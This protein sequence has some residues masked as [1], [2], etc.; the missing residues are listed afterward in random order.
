MGHD[1]PITFV[2]IHLLEGS[3]QVQHSKDGHSKNHGWLE[4]AYN[5]IWD[6]P[7]KHFMHV[8]HGPLLV[9]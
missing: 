3:L 8:L 6:R 7:L 4:S 9:K 2:I 1:I 5:T